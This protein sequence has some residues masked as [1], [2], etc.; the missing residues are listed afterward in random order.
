MC[1]NDIFRNDTAESKLCE[2]CEMPLQ[3]HSI[4]IHKGQKLS[5]IC[6]VNADVAGHRAEALQGI[7]VAADK[8][9]Q[10]SNEKFAPIEV[11]TTVLV[12]IP[13]F[14]RGTLDPNNIHRL[15]QNY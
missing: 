14:D 5:Q 13:T 8:M 4:F 7:Q 10:K 3:K 6:A 2:Q 12:P 11:G 1:S 9:V 15:V